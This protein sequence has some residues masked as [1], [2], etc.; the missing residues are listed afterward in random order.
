[1]KSLKIRTLIRRDFEKAFKHVDV[2]MGPTMPVLPFDIGERIDDP[3]QLYMCDILTVPANLTGC[4]AISVPCGFRN[5]LP[6]GLQIIGR[7]F[8]EE[9][10]LRAA[11]AFEQNTKYHKCRPPL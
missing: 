10:I 7:P 4:P 3:L 2:I 5:N 9:T 6:V 1:M 11:Y 8:D